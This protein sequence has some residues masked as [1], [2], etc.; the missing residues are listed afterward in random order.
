VEYALAKSWM[1]RG[2]VPDRLIG[3]SVGE[4][5]AACIAGV[6]TLPDALALV[7]ERGRLMQALPAGD[8]ISVRA[9]VG[10]IV[11]LL[12][13]ELVVAAVNAPSLCVVSG[14]SAAMPAFTT[15]LD[16][17][18][19]AWSR[20][21]TSHAF[22]SAMMEPAVEPLVQR[23][24]GMRLSA[25]GI[26][27]VSTATGAVL[28]AEEAADP[29]YW[30]R[31][32][33]QTVLFADA[34]RHVAGEGP[35]V[36][37]EVGPGQTLTT[38]TRQ[39]VG[40]QDGVTVAASLGPVQSPGSD[41]AA[42]ASAMGMLWLGGAAVDWVRFTGYRGQR[43]PLPTYPFERKRFWVDPPGAKRSDT[44]TVTTSAPAPN[45][46]PTAVSSAADPVQQLV[47]AQLELMRRQLEALST[48]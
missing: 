7:A 37:L 23:M 18:N 34:V 17:R 36:F 12:P 20:L 42:I 5:T 40:R 29:R 27:I 48:S 41:D 9:P 4:F 15:L 26:T 11:G 31:Q 32:L 44:A 47:E 45:G 43:I 22:H 39:I 46:T 10:D 19:V 25:P 33:R 35:H 30:G 1:R 16:Q 14:P 21:H 13:R 2:L 38:L 8:M 28:R 24:A 3:H 6:F